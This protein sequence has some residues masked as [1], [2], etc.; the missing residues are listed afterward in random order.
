MKFI[1][2]TNIYSGNAIIVNLANV[3]A[4]HRMV[5]DGNAFTSICMIGDENYH[6]KEPVED[7]L[8]LMQSGKIDS[9]SF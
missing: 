8:L 1:A 6:V 2:L 9:V 5:E 7:F 3:T 4:I